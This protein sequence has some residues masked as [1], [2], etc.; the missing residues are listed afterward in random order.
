MTVLPLASIH[1]QGPRIPAWKKLG[2]KL[3]NAGDERRGRLSHVEPEPAPVKSKKRKR[4]GKDG[5]HEVLVVHPAPAESIAEAH[6]TSPSPSPT[7]TAVSQPQIHTASRKRKSVTF[8]PETKTKD[9]DSI[10]QLF[11]S[12][13]NEY[14]GSE[15]PSF[16]PESAGNVFRVKGSAADGQSR[17]HKTAR[18]QHRPKQSPTTTTTTT[19][20]N[21]HDTPTDLHPAL[22]YL[23]TYFH[24]PQRW[25]F[26][27]VRQTYLLKHL[28]DF[29]R[30]PSEYDEALCSYIAGLRGEA[31]RARVTATLEQNQP[32]SKNMDDEA[33]V[34]ATIEQ[35]QPDSENMSDEV[36]R[37][38]EIRVQNLKAA[39]R[40]HLEKTT[41]W[42]RRDLIDPRDP[43][44]KY[45]TPEALKTKRSYT[46]ESEKILQK[47]K[48]QI[49]SEQ[50]Q[51]EQQQFTTAAVEPRADQ[52]S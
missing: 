8:T 36:R 27:K 24:S 32:D 14:K 47:I 31:V 12:W 18:R 1:Q 29:Q 35:T 34:M 44:G 16:R 17:S 22:V 7:C 11:Q 23:G 45:R 40:S 51:S 46:A 20:T 43:T 15:D 2:L 6:H 10:K 52:V 21:K 30:I 25:K 38:R 5:H 49:Q 13:V 33:L 41:S 42:K 37:Q 3:K 9:G 19:T 48:G 4:L 50:I 28:L 26:N 39:L